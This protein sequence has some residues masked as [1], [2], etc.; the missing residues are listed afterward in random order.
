VFDSAGSATPLTITFTNNS[1]AVSRSWLFVVKDQTGS[2]LPGASGQ[3]I[4]NGDGSPGV[5]SNA[6]FQ[7]A[8]PGGVTP[9]AITL[10]FGTL[11][12]FSGATNFSAG[13]DSTLR[14]GSQDGFAAG[15][16]VS[17]AFEADGTVVATYSNGKTARGQ[18][19]AL[20]FFTSPQMLVEAGGG[21]F[22]NPTQQPVALGT[23]RSGVFGA[24]AGGSVES[25]NVDL[26]QQFS[27]LIVTQRGY[28]ASS[29]VIT[30]ANEMIEQ[31][32]QITGRR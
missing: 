29:Q 8:P 17:A 2:L 12:G 5:V 7:L 10:D 22:E 16:L 6:T 13:A 24:L 20:A 26:A 31:L 1:S 9:T 15:S 32:F 30:T 23:P 25:A 18:Q 19:V 4:F 27:E 11:G 21:V 3:V 14:T 28:Q